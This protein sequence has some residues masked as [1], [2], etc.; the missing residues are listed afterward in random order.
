ME[1][2]NPYEKKYKQ[3]NMLGKGNYGNTSFTQAKFIKW[4][5]TMANKANKHPI[6]LLKKCSY[7]ECQKKTSKL[8]MDKYLFV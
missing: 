5:L 3:L 6:T 2:V 7:K 1:E 8:H 4:D